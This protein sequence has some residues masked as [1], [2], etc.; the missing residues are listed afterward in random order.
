MKMV[1]DK[2]N[3]KARH[4]WEEEMRAK[5]EEEYQRQKEEGTK[6]EEK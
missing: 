3:I 2:D 5:A 4:D 1:G 6:E